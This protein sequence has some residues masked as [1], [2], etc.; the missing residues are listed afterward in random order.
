MLGLLPFA[1]LRFA[2]DGMFLFF[3]EISL[4]IAVMSRRLALS[5]RGMEMVSAM[6]G[7]RELGSGDS[8]TIG[9]TGGYWGRTLAAGSCQA[10]FAVNGGFAVYL[11]DFVR[12]LPIYSTKLPMCR[13]FHVTM[14]RVKSSTSSLS[15]LDLGPDSIP[16]FL[17]D[18]TADAV[19]PTGAPTTCRVSLQ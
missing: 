13:W 8:G 6:C 15:D 3:C 16:G 14:R 4:R 1:L 5:C 7:T 17:T 10:H 9:G 12:S 18:P 11:V 2:M 19:T